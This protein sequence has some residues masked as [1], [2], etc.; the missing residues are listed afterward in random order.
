[1]HRLLSQLHSN[2]SIGGYKLSL[3]LRTLEIISFT[4]HFDDSDQGDI[5]IG[6]LDLMASLRHVGKLRK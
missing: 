2:V 1:M 6:L 4:E 5:K 3:L